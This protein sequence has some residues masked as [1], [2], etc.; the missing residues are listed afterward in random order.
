[1]SKVASAS[2]TLVRGSNP[3]PDGGWP[4]FLT[5]YEIA[6]IQEWNVRPP[7]GDGWGSTPEAE[8]RLETEAEGIRSRRRTAAEV[9]WGKRRVRHSRPWITISALLLVCAVGAG[10]LGLQTYQQMRTVEQQTASLEQDATN[11]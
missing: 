10:V 7:R 6:Y 1:M 8:H 9:R 11:G 3:A 4:W 5:D 2:P